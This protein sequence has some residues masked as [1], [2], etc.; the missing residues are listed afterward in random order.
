MADRRAAHPD[1]QAGPR[2]PRPRRQDHRPRPARRR[3]RGD[4][5]RPAPDAGDDRRGGAAGGRRRDRPQHP[6]RRA[7]DAVPR[8]PR[9]LLRAARRRRRADL[10]RRHHPARG[11]R[12]AEAARRPRDLHAGRQH[13]RH[14]RLG[15]RRRCGRASDARRDRTPRMERR[16]AIIVGS[17]PAGTA[18]A[19]ALH[20]R[21]P[22]LAREVL[23]L[24]K[25]RH[26]RPKVC[27]GGLIPAGRQWLHEHDIPFDVPH[28][29]VHRAQVVT[30]TRTVGHDDAR[31]LLRRSAATS[32]TR[33]S[34]TRARE[35]GIEIRENEPVQSRGARRRRRSRRRPARHVPRAA[36]HRRRRRRQPG[37]AAP[38][39]RR[40]RAH[41]PRRSWPTCR[42]TGR[43]G[44]ASRRR[45]YDFDFRILRRGLRGYL[46]AFPCLDRRRAARQHRRLRGDAVG[47]GAR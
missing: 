11:H 5:H 41:R 47:H 43:A 46:W 21:D 2:R 4:L 1:R 29:T 37:P 32:S 19:L 38:P 20:R 17:G 30:P 40:P 16:P 42:S 15:A 45:R 10:R 23:V 33:R 34:P 18:T 25:A 22:A 12:R 26:P 6:V 7:H 44:T 9:D 39:R 31:P 3:L 36:R 35:R 24:E 13:R 8:H 14:R 27:A 28:V